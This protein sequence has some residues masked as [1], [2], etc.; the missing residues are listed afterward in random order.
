VFEFGAEQNAS[1]QATEQSSLV[2]LR[3]DDL[4][5][6]YA[7]TS[8]H[9]LLNTEMKKLF[10]VILAS[11]GVV[12]TRF[13]AATAFWHL[14]SVLFLMDTAIRRAYMLVGCTASKLLC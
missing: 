11:F 1:L 9:R 13:L 4:N 10:W 8:M 2:G 7:I 6:Y 14:R 12:V 3:A 5:L